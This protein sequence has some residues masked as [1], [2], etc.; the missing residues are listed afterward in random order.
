MLTQLM[1][2]G[3]GFA[4]EAIRETLLTAMYGAEKKLVM[5]TPYFVPDEPLFE[6]LVTAAKRG[7]DVTL[8][9]PEQIDSVMARL[10]SRSQYADLLE[11]GVKVM[12]F[13]DGLLH[14]KTLVADEAFALIGTV[15]LDM[16]SLWLNFEI[17]LAVNDPDT[18]QQIRRL[19]SGYLAESVQLHPEAWGR[20]PRTERMAEGVLRLLGPLL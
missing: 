12:L 19:Q 4:R 16:R 18:A 6:G 2:S 17:S 3:P 15:N 1:P 20:R 14:T 9:V 13:T 11:A 7:V 5:T 10:A 8:I